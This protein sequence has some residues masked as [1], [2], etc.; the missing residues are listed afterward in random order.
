MVCSVRSNGK[1]LYVFS[2]SP[3]TPGNTVIP[4]STATGKIGKPITWQPGAG[5]GAS[6]LI[7][8]NGKTLYIAST[9]GTVTPI[10]TAT[11][12]AGKPITFGSQAE[13]GAVYMA[14]TPN[15]KTLYAFDSGPYQLVT[16]V[17]PISTATNTVGKPIKVGQWP[18]AIV[19]SPNGTTVY[20]A[21][22]GSGPTGCMIRSPQCGPGPQALPTSVPATVTPIS[23]AT[24]RPGQAITLG[25]AAYGLTMAITPN[26]RTVYVGDSKAMIPIGTATG[27]AGNPIKLGWEAGAM[28][29][30]AN[31]TTIYCLSA[32]NTG[33]GVVIPIRI[34]A[35]TVL[36]AINVGKWPAAIAIAP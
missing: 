3:Y 18:T 2:L 27:K 19:V 28:A 26:G 14:I 9:L 31:S 12:K 30:T 25:P 35:G 11:N 16:T 6:M 1:T 23:T 5:W 24:N 13:N 33:L 20:V 34:P 8:P 32:T 4:I 15:G 29:I 21:S 36:K 10:S 22:T 7:T 17:T